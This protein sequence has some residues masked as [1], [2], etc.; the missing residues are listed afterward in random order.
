M[1]TSSSPRTASLSFQIKS[2]LQHTYDVC[3]WLT[4]IMVPLIILVKILKE[5]GAIDVLGAWMAPIMELVGLPGAMGLVWASALLTNLYGGMIFYAGIAADYPL[6]IAQVTVLGSIML[7]AHNLPMEAA[8][9]RAAGVKLW[10]T[11]VSRVGGAILYGVILAQLYQWGDWF[12]TS[13]TL[14][15]QPEARDD[16]LQAWA[17]SE[18]QN[19]LQIYLIVFV[20]MTVMA[21][22]KAMKV[23]DLLNR[24]LVG[25]FLRICGIGK[26]ASMLTVSGMLLGLAYGSALIIHEARSGQ[27]SGKDIF[28]CMLLMGL[29]HSIVEDTLLMMLLGGEVYGLLVGRIIFAVVV[30]MLIAPFLTRV[31]DERFQKYLYHGAS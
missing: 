10:V 17:L 5:V 18:M 26:E 22:L 9:A 24:F 27:V 30:M 28:A 4:K 25:P 3:W 21:L 19:L 1:T 11:L 31:D 12:Q 15:W 16:S 29:C 2:L 13:S 6:T 23:T 20:L 14:V 7:I 8:V